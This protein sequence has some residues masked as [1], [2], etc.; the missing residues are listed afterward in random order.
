ME[1]RVPFKPYPG[2]KTP[3]PRF[4][5]RG[6]GVVQALHEDVLLV[7]RVI[8]VE[9]LAAF[10]SQQLSFGTSFTGFWITGPNCWFRQSPTPNWNWR[11]ST[12]SGVLGHEQGLKE[13]LFFSNRCHLIKLG[14]PTPDVGPKVLSPIRQ[15]VLTSAETS[16]NNL[17]T[18]AGTA[19]SY[20]HNYI[21]WC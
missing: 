10:R 16:V 7:A 11:C 20:Q 21:H 4:Q 9:Y 19:G 1:I 8:L 12:W 6:G 3:D 2:S 14:Q 13:T 5:L 15:S 18:T 17:F